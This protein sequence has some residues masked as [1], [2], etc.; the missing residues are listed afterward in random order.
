MKHKSLTVIVLLALLTIVL[1]FAFAILI[2]FQFLS[3]VPSG[4][5]KIVTIKPQQSSAISNAVIQLF[6][7]SSDIDWTKVKYEDGRDIR[8]YDANGNSLRYYKIYFSRTQKIGIFYILLPTLPEV[9][10]NIQIYCSYGQEDSIVSD[11]SIFYDCKN[12]DT[13]SVLWSGSGVSISK[14]NGINVYGEMVNFTTLDS[15]TRRT[16]IL[17]M[18]IPSKFTITFA[19]MKDNTY[20]GSDSWSEVMVYGQTGTGTFELLFTVTVYN[21]GSTTIDTLNSYKSSSGT[22]QNKNWYIF[23]VSYNSD[24]RKAQFYVRKLDG[25]LVHQA[26]DIPISQ[27]STYGSYSCLLLYHKS[28]YYQTIPGSFSFDETVISPTYLE[29][30][31]IIEFSGVPL[32]IRFLTFSDLTFPSSTE[33]TLTAQFIS[34]GSSLVQ[35]QVTFQIDAKQDYPGLPIGTTITDNSGIA[36]V[37]FTTP[38]SAYS[39]YTLRITVQDVGEQ[40]FSMKVLKAFKITY[41]KIPTT[42]EYNLQGDYDLIIEGSVVDKENPNLIVTGF[43]LTPTVK[44][45]DGRTIETTMLV[46]S[47]T[48]TVKSRVYNT[49][50][51][52]QERNVTVSLTFSMAGYWTLTETRYVYMVQPRIQAVLLEPQTTVFSVGINKIRLSFQGSQ[53]STLTQDLIK[54]VIVTPDGTKID[55]ST[56]QTYWQSDTY[57]TYSIWYTFD[58][59]GTYKLEITVNITPPQYQDITL[60]VTE[61]GFSIP[62]QYIVIGIIILLIL[63]WLFKR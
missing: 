36:T 7:K 54:V 56:L 37:T 12:Y 20:T 34:Y 40:T 28:I 42:C 63:Y 18:N 52:L 35:K 32:E 46:Q 1:I 33:V 17:A 4:N 5:Y 62:W 39:P 13:S 2:K 9:G 11:S 38:S 30:E 53:A 26:L 29:R 21:D 14:I 44:G 50:K 27:K 8:F 22:I 59:P 25:T 45:P 55:S 16:S 51:D 23:T 43:T 24:N 48:F 57:P 41:S 19:Y 15:S 10:F 47:N 31:P 49:Y 61:A 3:F 60:Y 6:I 58:K